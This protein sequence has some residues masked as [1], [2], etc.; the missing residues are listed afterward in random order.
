LYN[1]TSSTLS[2][3]LLY[4]YGSIIEANFLNP[5]HNKQDF[6]DTPAYRNC[7]LALAL[8]LEAYWYGQKS[9]YTTIRRRPVSLVANDSLRAAYH[10][11]EGECQ[12]CSIETTVRQSSEIKFGSSVLALYL[13]SL[14]DVLTQRARLQRT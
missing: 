10:A 8:R 14:S 13:I 12:A 3:S 9:S 4:T 2:L 5:T 7:L 1:V 11:Q 6:D